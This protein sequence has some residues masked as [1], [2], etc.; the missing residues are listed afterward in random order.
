MA[1]RASDISTFHPLPKCS[2]FVAKAIT[3]EVPLVVRRDCFTTAGDRSS[4]VTHAGNAV[5]YASDKYATRVLPHFENARMR[6]VNV[7]H[8]LETRDLPIS[9]TKA[10][11]FLGLRPGYSQ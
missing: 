2:S 11:F 10:R 1:V 6:H 4:A 7:S 9:S 5:Q 3:E 8:L